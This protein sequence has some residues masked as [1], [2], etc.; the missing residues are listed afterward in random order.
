VTEPRNW[1][2]RHAQT[3]V[4]EV[5]QVSAIAPWEVSV[6]RESDATRTRTKGYRRYGF[7]ADAYIGADTLA[8]IAL[9]HSCDERC[10]RWQPVASQQAPR[11]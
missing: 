6:W 5:S 3:I 7:L 9:A 1:Q 8:M 4:T 2:R 11:S 10:G